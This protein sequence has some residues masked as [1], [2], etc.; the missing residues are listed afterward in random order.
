MAHEV[1]RTRTRR[2]TFGYAIVLL[3]AALFVT[4]S[5]LPYYAVGAGERTISLFELLTQRPLGADSYLGAP[6]YLFGGVAPVAVVAVIALV[7]GQR[8]PVLPS[9][10]VGAVIAWSLTWIG[11]LVN[12]GTFSV[13]VSFEIG[14]WLQ[15]VSIG[16]AVIGTIFVG[17]GERREVKNSHDLYATPEGIDADA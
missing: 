11:V 9:V 7:R 6:L 14:F 3:G 1:H 8:G 13:N 15:A 17:F 5:F 2:S 10:L 16:V 4:S 12:T